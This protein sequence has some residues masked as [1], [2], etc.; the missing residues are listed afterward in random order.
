MSFS[1]SDYGTTEPPA[2]EPEATANLTPSPFALHPEAGKS[3]NNGHTA[4]NAGTMP[5]VT[6]QDS[7]PFGGLG[8]GFSTPKA[9]AKQP[10]QQQNAHPPQQQDAESGNANPKN[11]A[12]KQG[13][14]SDALASALKAGVSTPIVKGWGT[15]NSGGSEEKKG[16]VPDVIH[17]IKNN[18]DLFT[19]TALLDAYQQGYD[20]RE[21]FKTNMLAAGTPHVFAY[22]AHNDKNFQLRLGFCPTLCQIGEDNKLHGKLVLFNV[23]N[24]FPV[25]V[26]PAKFWTWHL[27]GSEGKKPQEGEKEEPYDATITHV[28]LALLVPPELVVSMHEWSSKNLSSWKCLEKLELDYPDEVDYP[29][30]KQWLWEACK[31]KTTKSGGKHSV[32][33]LSLGAAV[34]NTAE[35]KWK[36]EVLSKRLGVSFGAS[37]TAPAATQQNLMMHLMMQQQQQSAEQLELLREQMRKPPAPVQVTVQHASGAGSATTGGAGGSKVS[38]SQSKT[39]AVCSLAYARNPTGLPKFW[40]DM[41]GKTK[42][43]ALE[44]WGKLE[45]K[46]VN[47]CRG[48]NF[49]CSN[50][51]KPRPEQVWDIVNGEFHCRGSFEL[52]G[53][54]GLTPFLTIPV[55]FA[56]QQK[57]KNWAKAESAST[58]TRTYEEQI[59][60]DAEKHA[61]PNPPATHGQLLNN[62]TAYMGVLALTIGWYNS[63]YKQVRQL[64]ELLNEQQM[65]EQEGKFLGAFSREIFWLVLTESKRYCRQELTEEE[66]RRNAPFPEAGISSWLHLIRHS[67]HLG[68][69]DMPT[70]W[71]KPYV[72]PL[73]PSLVTSPQ[74]FQIPP[75]NVP[76]VPTNLPRTPPTARDRAAAALT[77]AQKV[78]SSARLIHVFVA[79]G[80]TLATLP[81]VQGK[82][83]CYNHLLGRCTSKKCRFEHVDANDVTPSVMNELA[84]ICEQ[85]ADKIEA[86]GAL[87]TVDNKRRKLN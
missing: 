16:E 2:N 11:S 79:A 8:P 14:M 44:L 4:P 84:L 65:R 15:D 3:P 51:W 5:P 32:L 17:Y 50:D 7:S 78:D 59:R 67:D 23:G 58:Q 82:S 54:K 38:L 61:L 72:A 24:N 87:P 10:P 45:K 27:V 40:F 74:S 25:V 76:T 73:P 6:Q 37:N 55:T 9:A 85:G 41:N 48:E 21:E 70:A 69:S 68:L 71:K 22:M 66:Q 20:N 57:R 12:V 35:D 29:M 26:P 46:I 1:L 77:R 64:V 86:D 63:L 18:S 80:R 42:T 33:G 75:H 62:M 60:I 39:A 53:N 56:E 47:W 31:E 34:M 13:G 43:E 49:P 52:E 19:T 30:V 36:Q 81:Q 28:P 83:S